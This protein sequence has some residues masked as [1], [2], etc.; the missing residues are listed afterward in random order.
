MRA[1]IY[2]R[3][4]TLQQEEGTSPD[5]QEEVFRPVEEIIGDA[6]GPED[7][8]GEPGSDADPDQPDSSGAES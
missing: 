5:T 6:G 3:V 2:V 1:A 4:S 7:V 8:S